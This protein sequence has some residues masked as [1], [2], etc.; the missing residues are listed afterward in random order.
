ME[1]SKEWVRDLK[2]AVINRD[3][4]FLE[5]LYQSL[6]DFSQT[7][8]SLEELLEVEA[9]VGSATEILRE[10]RQELLGNMNKL[11][12]SIAYQKNMIN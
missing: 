11:K 2:V 4:K 12:A 9:L 8:L 5:R 6:P 10:N 3:S 7:D 1:N